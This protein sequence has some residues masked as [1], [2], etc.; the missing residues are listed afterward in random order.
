MIALS[1][2]CRHGGTKGLQD[3]SRVQQWHLY[4]FCP[5]VGDKIGKGTMVL[6][7]YT[8]TLRRFQYH[9]ASGAGL[10]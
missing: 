8:P 9:L 7:Q 5:T 3:S 4:R 1:V 10:C 6:F 2:E